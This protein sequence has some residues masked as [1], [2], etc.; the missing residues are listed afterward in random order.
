MCTKTVNVRKAAAKMVVCIEKRKSKN[1]YSTIP[2]KVLSH[3]VTESTERSNE[4]NNSRN[5]CGKNK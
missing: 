2:T 1:N 5:G 4:R 3:S